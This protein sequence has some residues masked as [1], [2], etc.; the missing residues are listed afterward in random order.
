M[1]KKRE[2]SRDIFDKALDY[3][4][5]VGAGV[6]FAIGRRVGLKRVDRMDKKYMQEA[7]RQE[8]LESAARSNPSRAN[9]DAVVSGG[10]R[11]QDAEKR[12]YDAVRP[13]G[14]A[15]AAGTAAGTGGG[16]IA[17]EEIRKRRK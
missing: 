2:D 4:P 16:Y 12:L 3:A 9:T 6:G 5:V 13:T 8:R 15:A 14:R 17:A 1:S 7:R 11:M 10:R